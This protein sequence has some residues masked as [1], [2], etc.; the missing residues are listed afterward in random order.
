[1][2]KPSSVNVYH[3]MSHTLSYGE[4]IISQGL[5]CVIFGQI[6]IFSSAF[7]LL[8]HTWIAWLEGR[9]LVAN[10]LM[11]PYVPILDFRLS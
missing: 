4:N 6:P 1:M 11:G 9:V 8:L 10:L 3:L 2:G 5:G 7:E